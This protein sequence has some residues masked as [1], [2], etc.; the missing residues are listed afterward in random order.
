MIKKYKFIIFSVLLYATCLIGCGKENKQ[1]ELKQQTQDF[2]QPAASKPLAVQDTDTNEF[3]AEDVDVHSIF[4]DNLLSGDN[5]T[6]VV[7]TS[8]VISADERDIQD[9]WFEFSKKN[10]NSAVLLGYASYPYY[11]S[12]VTDIS[13]DEKVVCYDNGKIG[14]QVYILISDDDSVLFSN[15]YY[16]DDYNAIVNWLSDS[17]T[18]LKNNLDSATDEQKK[19]K[20][21]ERLDDLDLIFGSMEYQGSTE[22]YSSVKNFKDIYDFEAILNNYYNL[23]NCEYCTRI[24]RMTCDFAY[25]TN[26]EC[27]IYR[28]MTY[29]NCNTF[30]DVYVGTA[31]DL[32]YEVQEYDKTDLSLSNP[33]SVMSIGHNI[34]DINTKSTSNDVT[35]INDTQAQSK[36]DFV[37]STVLPVFNYTDEISEAS[38]FSLYG[39]TSIASIYNTRMPLYTDDITKIMSNENSGAQI[40]NYANGVWISQN[41]ENMLVR[42]LYKPS[43]IS[44]SGVVKDVPTTPVTI[45]ISLRDMIDA[46]GNKLGET[47]LCDFEINSKYS[48]NTYSQGQLL[49]DAQ[50]SE[51]FEIMYKNLKNFK[52]SGLYDASGIS[53][54]YDKFVK[55]LNDNSDIISKQNSSNNQDENANQKSNTDNQSEDETSKDKVFDDSKSEW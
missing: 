14:R 40:I 7:D 9:V 45:A 49:S 21:A 23:D 17:R 11:Y 41:S 31:D 15:S 19:Y 55:W 5:Y 27:D 29:E 46:N 18:T 10:G 12:D 44:S 53:F 1:V 2:I 20:Y 34:T 37:A 32:I 51:I 42:F 8:R 35:E 30:Y 54:D 16:F 13:S 43:N 47:Y 4:G 24:D 28:I 26:I 3:V 36:I 6:A 22:V 33:I 48:L 52:D 50:T 25:A 38:G 39:E